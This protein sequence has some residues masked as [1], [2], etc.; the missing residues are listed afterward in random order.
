MKY[1][2]FFSEKQEKEGIPVGG[3]TLNISTAH[4]C[5][6]CLNNRFHIR[7]QRKDCCYWY[8]LSRCAYCGEAKNIVVR[9]NFWGRVKLFL[10]GM[11]RR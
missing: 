1:R 6:E 10:A 11:L 9:L 3:K 2:S 7:L 4:S 5:R 8:Y